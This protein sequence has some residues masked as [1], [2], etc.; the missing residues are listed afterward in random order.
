MRNCGLSSPTSLQPRLLLCSLLWNP[1]EPKGSCVLSHHS[2]PT[3]PVLVLTANSEWLF[4]PFFQR[5]KELS[6]WFPAPTVAS[7]QT[8]APSPSPGLRPLGLC[9]APIVLHLLLSRRAVPSHP[10]LPPPTAPLHRLKA[11][12][13][14]QGLP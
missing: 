8:A 1:L 10:S 2:H 13:T 7:P 3:G 5:F 12:H 9:Q 4:W 6:A 11:K 14:L